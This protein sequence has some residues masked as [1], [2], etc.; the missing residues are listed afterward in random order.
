MYEVELFH[1]F[2]SRILQNDQTAQAEQSDVGLTIHL[3]YKL[4]SGYIFVK[5]ISLKWQYSGFNHM[6]ESFIQLFSAG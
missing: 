5:I 3:Y 6:L 4:P 2:S 1:Q